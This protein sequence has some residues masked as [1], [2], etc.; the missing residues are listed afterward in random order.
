M[1]LSRFLT[2]DN[3]ETFLNSEVQQTYHSQTG[4]VEE[5]LKKYAI[6]CKIAEVAKTGT[7]RILDMFFGIGYNSAMAIDVALESN[8]D[9]K[10]EIVAVENDPEIIK[11]I[12]EV[13]PPIKSYTLYKELVRGNEIKENQKFIYEANN[14]KITLFVDDAQKAA[15][16]LPEKYFDAIFYDPFSPKAQPDMWTVELFKEMYRVMKDSG[17]LA[18][19]SCARIIRDNLSKADLVYDDGPI[20]GRRGPGTIATKWI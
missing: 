4:A 12:L 6:P 8:P 20:I 19:Y 1:K 11:K 16:K 3:T 18:T 17:I 7:V 14:I 10:I 15:K 9:C 13:K 2:L 5:A